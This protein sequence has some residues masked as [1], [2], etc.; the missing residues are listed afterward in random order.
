M[1]RSNLEKETSDAIPFA[2]SIGGEDYKNVK[3]EFVVLPDIEWNLPVPGMKIKLSYLY[4]YAEVDSFALVKKYWINGMPTKV[5]KNEINLNW[6]NLG[7]QYCKSI[8]TFDLELYYVNAKSNNMGLSMFNPLAGRWL[9]NSIDARIPSQA[10]DTLDHGGLYLAVNARP[11]SWLS[12]GGYYQYYDDQTIL[13]D[14]KH[15][16]ADSLRYSND[17]ALTLGFMYSDM[18]SLKIEGHNVIGTALIEPNLNVNPKKNWQYGI[19]KVSYN[20]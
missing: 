2:R 16:F 18:L 5:A 4:A 1:G 10:N 7:I 20:F 11:I 3:S 15:W 6:Y 14:K 12:V 13:R 8:F 9:N 19:V 17:M